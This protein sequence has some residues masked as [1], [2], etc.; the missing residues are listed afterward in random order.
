VHNHTSMVETAQPRAAQTPPQQ[1][2][3]AQ[4]PP[5]SEKP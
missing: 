2:P 5:P 3:A 4:T 1:P